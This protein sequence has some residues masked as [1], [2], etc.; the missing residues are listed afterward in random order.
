[1]QEAPGGAN[2]GRSATASRD[3]ETERHVS[4]GVDDAQAHEFLTD[5]GWSIGTVKDGSRAGINAHRG[6]LRG[7]EHIDVDAVMGAV[8]DELGF[9][10]DEIHSVYRQGRMTDSQRELR[11]R[12][13]ARLLA[14][15]RSGANM[16]ALARLLGFAYDEPSERFKTM[17]RALTRARTQEDA[18]RRA[19]TCDR[20]GRETPAVITP[21]RACPA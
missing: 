13:D 18:K 17:E 9:T 3:P 6:V 20:C 5:G 16:A 21:C 15:S 7:D 1:M 11:G 10:I 2:H 12:I 4:L 14:L 19:P 8:E